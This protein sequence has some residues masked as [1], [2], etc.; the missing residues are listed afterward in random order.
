MDK[1]EDYC[2]ASVTFFQKLLT[3]NFFSEWIDE[4]VIDI[5][6]SASFPIEK[7]EFPTATL[8]PKSSNSDR[9]GPVIKTFDYLPSFDRM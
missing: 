2:N 6:D 9:L 8:C 4:P 7:V 1:L 5:L 3:E